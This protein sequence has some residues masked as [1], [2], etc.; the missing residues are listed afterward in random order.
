QP[1]VSRQIAT[2]EQEA[3][4]RLVE[5]S[6]RG[7][8]L[9]P[10]GELFMAMKLVGG[11]SWADLLHPRTPEQQE[12]ARRHDREAHVQTLLAVC[13][14]VAFAHSKGIVHR[15]LKPE[16]VMV[17]DFGEVLVMDWGIAVDVSER[18]APDA[19]APHRTTVAS[20]SGTPSYMPPELAEGRGEEIGPWTD[21]YL[22]GATLHEVLTTL[23]RL[24]APIVPHVADAMWENLVVAVD[25]QAPD[26]VHLV[27]FP[28]S[29]P[30]R[31]DE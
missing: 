15:D 2:L 27:D 21:V 11:T 23:A 24:L 28:T 9:T 26:S 22:L 25:P 10:A 8:R 30:G 12:R 17:G 20:P 16:N 29:V 3:G 13:N 31:R 19:R 14:A 5:R 1:A 18:P 4:T 6:A 7:I